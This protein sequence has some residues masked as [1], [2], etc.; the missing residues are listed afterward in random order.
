MCAVSPAHQHHQQQQ[1]I[2]SDVIT[3]VRQSVR[4]C[5]DSVKLRASRGA[6]SRINN[7]AM[8]YVLS[9]W[10]HRVDLVHPTIRRTYSIY[11]CDTS[12]FDHGICEHHE[13]ALSYDMHIILRSMYIKYIFGIPTCGIPNYKPQV[14]L[15]CISYSSTFHQVRETVICLVQTHILILKIA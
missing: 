10:M 14:L 7:H 6:F 1:T 13:K 9:A 2:E 11:L 8:F 4:D 15:V 5:D 3:S 12:T